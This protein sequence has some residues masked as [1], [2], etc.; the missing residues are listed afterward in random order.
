MP[1]NV[2]AVIANKALQQSS[3][4]PCSP[5]LCIYFSAPLQHAIRRLVINIMFHN[6]LVCIYYCG[7]EKCLILTV[8]FLI[9]RREF[10]S[11]FRKKILSPDAAILLV[12]V[13]KAFFGRILL[14][15]NYR[16]SS[17]LMFGVSKRLL[18]SISLAVY[19]L[20]LYFVKSKP[21]TAFVFS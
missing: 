16:G 11:I 15:V 1:N 21:Q 8:A 20:S 10:A 3:A 14:R 4:P 19:C 12:S 18:R 6:R 7:S 9:L 13:T 2:V 5:R 17:L